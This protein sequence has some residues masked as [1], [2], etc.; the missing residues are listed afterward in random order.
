M[1]LLFVHDTKFK[2]DI[3]GTYYTGG[4][5]SEKIWNRYLSISSELSVIARKEP[6]IYSIEDAKKV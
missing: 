6:Y 1:K 3:T 4:S 2:E 5:Y